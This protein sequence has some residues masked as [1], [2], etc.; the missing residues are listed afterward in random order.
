MRFITLGGLTAAALS[1]CAAATTLYDYIVVGGGPSGIIAAERLAE[2]NK[3][4]LLLERGHGSTSGTGSS[5]SLEWNN[6]LTP[7]DVPGLSGGLSS[8]TGLWSDYLCNDTS[9]LY[10]ACVLGG[11]V[12]VNYMV[13]VH[14]PARDFDDKWPTGWK[15]S[16]VEP[17]ANRLYARNPGSSAPSADGQRYDQGLYTTLSSFFAKLGWSAVDMISQ[18]DAKHEV[19]SHP[20]WN[21]KNAMRA[22]PV[23]TYLPLAQARANFSLRLRAKVN[24]LV[25]DSS[26]GSRVTGVLVENVDTGALETVRLASNGAVVLAAGALHTPQLLFNSGIG[27]AAQIDIAN[28]SGA[29]VPP[30]SQWIDLPVGKS[31]KDHP[32]FYITVNTSSG[33]N[34]SA[35][36]LVDA[37]DVFSGTD[38]TN[39]DLYESKAQGVLTQG[40][41]RLVFFS[42]NVGSD[43]VTRYY[44]GSCAASGPDTVTMTTYLTHGATS[45]G[46]LEM[47]TDGSVHF[48]TPPYLQTAADRAAATSFVEGL[49][50]SL[51]DASTGFSLVTDNVTSIIEN[52]GTGIHYA[53]TAKIGTD[54]GRNGG[55]A[56][57]DTN[58]K[59]YGTDNLYIV[60]GSIHPDLASGNNQATIMVVAEAAVAKILACHR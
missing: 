8:Q 43:G 3:K 14:P 12:S 24:R 10:A 31:L 26:T 15:W 40:R 33:V 58:T 46:V 16:D 4:V 48:S 44:Q 30:K 54:D 34:S 47:N 23:R 19:Y 29:A 25:R 20:S 11:G 5:F 7:I 45:T 60:D 41:H 42:S 56:V 32:I 49:L 51:G 9:G 6:S 22:G 28:T 38:V 27:P 35:Y 36:D 59:V 18:P 55:S 53:G 52:Y 37:T 39:I 13:F 2:T 17:A 1:Q 50:S 21:I 57:V